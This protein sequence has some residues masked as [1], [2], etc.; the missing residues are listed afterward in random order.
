MK[1]ALSPATTRGGNIII[2]A[3]GVPRP[4]LVCEAQE[5]IGFPPPGVR[6]SARPD[7]QTWLC[8]FFGARQKIPLARPRG[9]SLLAS[10]PGSFLVSA[11]VFESHSR[12]GT[13]LLIMF[14]RLLK[15]LGAV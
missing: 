12:D 14:G 2:H 13:G 1:H 15:L 11:E 8:G 6:T 3:E 4:L 7:F 10:T 9:C 5:R